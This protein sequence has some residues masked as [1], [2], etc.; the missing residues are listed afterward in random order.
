MESTS[1]GEVVR[2]GQ[3]EV[4]PRPP[5]LPDITYDRAISQSLALTD[6]LYPKIEN[7]TDRDMT[8]L[9]LTY[10]LA[11]A[12]VI[13]P[14]MADADKR[15]LWAGA[16]GGQADNP[17]LHIDTI[18]AVMVEKLMALPEFSGTPL[19]GIYVEEAGWGDRLQPDRTA[20]DSDGSAATYMIIDPI[21]ASKTVTMPKPIPVTGVVIPDGNGVLKTGA[22]ISHVDNRLLFYDGK[23]TA[24]YDYDTGKNILTGHPVHRHTD[25]P[26]EKQKYATHKK[27]IAEYPNL[28]L[29]THAIHHMDK[30]G[31][32]A[33]LDLLDGEFHTIVDPKGQPPHDELFS[34][35]MAE[36][37]GLVVSTTRGEPVPYAEI[38]DKLIDGQSMRVPYVVSCTRQVHDATLANLQTDVKPYIRSNN[39]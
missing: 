1:E 29:W 35:M 38:L 10:A 39:P 11:Q 28:K 12:N 5:E 6:A 14:I 17:Y 4:P 19:T 36:K 8:R 32:Y 16:W 21:D 18:G 27:R 25:H 26:G 23:K 3:A 37:A 13:R 20:K 15:K 22:I 2:F 24:L 30:I 34:A 7:D 31:G 33:I 9:C